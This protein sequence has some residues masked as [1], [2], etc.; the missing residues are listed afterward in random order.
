MKSL[1]LGEKALGGMDKKIHYRLVNT[2]EKDR[3]KNND[4]SIAALEGKNLLFD[5]PRVY[6][7]FSANKWK[8]FKSRSDYQ[9]KMM[10]KEKFA[11]QLGMKMSAQPD[12]SLGELLFLVYN[13]HC[14]LDVP[15]SICN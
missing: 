9:R 15:F 14:F 7:R 4:K 3:I 10:L 8:S 12:K 5:S 1:V 13:I 11:K 6:D 2:G